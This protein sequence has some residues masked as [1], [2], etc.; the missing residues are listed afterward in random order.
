MKLGVCLRNIQVN[1]LDV[2]IL[3]HFGFNAK[4]RPAGALL[5]DEVGSDGLKMSS[6][7]IS[8]TEDLFNLNGRLI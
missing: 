3:I 5:F 6:Q 2:S 8:V 7:S 1:C 4:E